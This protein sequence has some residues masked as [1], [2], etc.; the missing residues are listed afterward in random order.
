MNQNLHAHERIPHRKVSSTAACWLRS[1]LQ[2]LP[3][4]AVLSAS[5]PALHDE[6][7]S[8]QVSDGRGRWMGSVL[9]PPHS[10]CI[11]LLSWVAMAD[12]RQGTAPS[13]IS[14][15]T[16]EQRGMMH[17]MIRWPFTGHSWIEAVLYCSSTHRLSGSTKH[18]AG[19][20][21]RGT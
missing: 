7:R 5:S 17:R 20:R 16:G 13:S 2:I 10:N 12:A 4:S 9:A 15:R 6:G 19:G 3:S 11:N 18:M 14:C 8:M 1:T 21:K